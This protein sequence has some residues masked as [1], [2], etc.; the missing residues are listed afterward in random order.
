M[1]VAVVPVPGGLEPRQDQLKELVDAGRIAAFEV[2]GQEVVLY[3]RGLRP[4]EEVQVPLSV[5]AAIPGEYTGAAS[6]A[7]AYYDDLRKGYQPGVKV[8]VAPRKR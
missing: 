6:R 1:P 8:K 7:Y 2:Q 3:W 4:G 5:T